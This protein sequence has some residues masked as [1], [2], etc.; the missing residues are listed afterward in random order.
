MRD[1]KSN[2]GTPRVFQSPSRHLA[3]RKVRVS[4]VLAGISKALMT[5]QKARKVMEVGRISRWN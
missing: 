2:V 5:T 3:V 1:R 4:R